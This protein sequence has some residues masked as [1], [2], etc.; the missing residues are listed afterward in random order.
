MD[1]SSPLTYD[2][3]LQSDSGVFIPAPRETLRGKRLVL[4]PPK[5]DGFL[6]A[7]FSDLKTMAYV[8]Q[9]H[10]AVAWTLD[11]M[12]QLRLQHEDDF[13]HG[14]AAKALEYGFQTLALT[15][16]DSEGQCTHARMV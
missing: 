5:D 10:R 13:L 11:E 9:Y 15:R 8:P 2:S 3:L 14:K 6:C 16:V 7:I 1:P 4:K 12:K